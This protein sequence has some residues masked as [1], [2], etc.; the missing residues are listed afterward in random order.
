MVDLKS[1]CNPCTCSR[2]CGGR[3]F[4]KESVMRWLIQLIFHE[5]QLKEQQCFYSANRSGEIPALVYQLL[6]NW[7][8][9]FTN[10]TIWC[11]ASWL[12]NMSSVTWRSYCWIT[13]PYRFRI[14][15]H[16][17]CLLLLGHFSCFD[18]RP[19]LWILGLQR[20]ELHSPSLQWLWKLKSFFKEPFYMCWSDSNMC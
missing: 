10:F 2:S 11:P 14:G 17:P 8:M 1:H 3:S 7:F 16:W 4:V 6:P 15:A 18:I 5:R 20:W 12:G 13:H 9:A 19:L